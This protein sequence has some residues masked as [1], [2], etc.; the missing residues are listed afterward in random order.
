MSGSC[1]SGGCL[2]RYFTLNAWA[3]ARISFLGLKRD[4]FNGI[5]GFP[6]HTGV[7]KRQLV[8]IQLTFEQ[9]LHQTIPFI[10]PPHRFIKGLLHLRTRLTDHARTIG[11]THLK[12]ILHKDF[13]FLLLKSDLFLSFK[14]L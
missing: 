11:L 5:I 14:V 6:C 1:R 12:V 10:S 2:C 4:F 8:L 13:F 3:K 9:I 7:S